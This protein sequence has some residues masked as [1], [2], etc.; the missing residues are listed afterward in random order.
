MPT[1]AMVAWTGCG[2]QSV[3]QNAI[4]GY[5]F[6]YLNSPH[7][8]PHSEALHKTISLTSTSLPRDMWGCSSTV[9][10]R[11]SSRQPLTKGGITTVFFDPLAPSV[12]KDPK[13]AS[14]TEPEKVPAALLAEY[15][16]CRPTPSHH[17]RVLTPSKAALVFSKPAAPVTGNDSNNNDREEE[18]QLDDESAIQPITTRKDIFQMAE[19]CLKL[20]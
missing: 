19:R 16:K 8:M 11:M 15:Q 18:M 9:P 6:V 5:T 3:D 4:Q 7:R 20:G 17:K 2:F 10:L 12:L 14:T 13:L 1:A